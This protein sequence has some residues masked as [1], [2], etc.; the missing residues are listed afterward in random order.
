[1]KLEDEELEREEMELDKM[2]KELQD[3]KAS[4][5]FGAEEKQRELVEVKTIVDLDRQK[6]EQEKIQ[7]L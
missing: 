4:G 5:T 1:M 2:I 7:K 6:I 3:A